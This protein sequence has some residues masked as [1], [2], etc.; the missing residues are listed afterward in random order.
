MSYSNTFEKVRYFSRL[1]QNNLT[2]RKLYHLE[3]YRNSNTLIQNTSFLK[4]E[5]P[6]RLSKRVFDLD[7]IK[8]GLSTNPIIL[9]IKDLYLQSAIRSIEHREIKNIAD[10]ISFKDLIKDIKEKHSN[11]VENMSQAVIKTSKNLQPSEK[12]ELDYFL[13]NFY[14]SRIGIRTIIGQCVNVTEKSVGIIKKIKPKSI[15]DEMKEEVC[16]ISQQCYGI[17]PKFVFHGDENYEI[18]YIP[19]FLQYIYLELL[20]NASRA[21][22]E[23]TNN[24]EP[25]HI[26]QS[27]GEN[28]LIIKIS[29]FGK[30][31]PRSILQ[32]VYSYSFT[33]V[34]NNDNNG[35]NNE[36]I[37]MAG[38]G[39]GVPLARLYA[40]YFGGDIQLIPYNGI[41]TDVIIYINR[42]L[43]YEEKEY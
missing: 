39:Y 29:D 33:T 32:Q 25:I 17:E 10:A 1:P 27:C 5:I 6:I 41:G 30:G 16:Y 21:V 28:D 19:S 8:F 2:L 38:L 26:Y 42:L 18:T 9:S 11:V 37:I 43:D 15:F 23:N 22:I 35:N 14:G 7:S 36:H 31:F 3:K 12:V 13:T 4:K 24:A 20:K 40:R 34:G